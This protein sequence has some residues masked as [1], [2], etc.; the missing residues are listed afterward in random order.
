MTCAYIL[1]EN[2]ENDGCLNF[3]LT[4]NEDEILKTP[5]NDTIFVN[6][7]KNAGYEQLKAELERRYPIVDEIFNK[8]AILLE[9]RFSSTYSHSEVKFKINHKLEFNL[10]STL[11]NPEKFAEYI[12]E[13]GV[14]ELKNYSQFRYSYH[15]RPI[16]LKRNLNKYGIYVRPIRGTLEYNPKMAKKQ[17]DVLNGSKKL[18]K[19]YVDLN[20]YDLKGLKDSLKSILRQNLNLEISHT[21]ESY[22]KKKINICRYIVLY[23]DL[24]N[25]FLEQNIYR[26]LQNFELI[27]NNWIKMKQKQKM[28]YPKVFRSFMNQEAK[29]DV[30]VSDPVRCY[31]IKSKINSKNFSLTN[32]EKNKFYNKLNL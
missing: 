17:A 13:Y 4:N 12:K 23:A 22:H 16:S 14:F 19:K 21:Y 6:E 20:H 9:D 7:N 26:R 10:D 28:Q 11:S 27:K 3:H 1:K 24:C 15:A 2:D 32:Y 31:E 30:P 25:L 8:Y 29:V 18:K 5:V